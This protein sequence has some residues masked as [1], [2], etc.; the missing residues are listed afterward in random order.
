MIFQ[1]LDQ[2]GVSQ[3]LPETRHLP[4]NFNLNDQTA[5]ER[6]HDRL[7]AVMSGEKRNEVKEQE[8]EDWNEVVKDIFDFTKPD[9]QRWDINPFNRYLLIKRGETALLL[10]VNRIAEARL[11]TLHELEEKNV[12]YRR[13][14]EETETQKK[15]AFLDR[16]REIRA[17]S[18]AQ[19]LVCWEKSDLFPYHQADLDPQVIYDNLEAFAFAAVTNTEKLNLLHKLNIHETN[20]FGPYFDVALKKVAVVFGFD[21]DTSLQQMTSSLSETQPNQ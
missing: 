18:F 21:K 10:E 8:V 1:D 3:Q 12:K 9:C 19:Q 2:H 4:I 20:V 7:K 6:V 13:D 17:M 16:S 15:Q 14:R 5:A 11:R